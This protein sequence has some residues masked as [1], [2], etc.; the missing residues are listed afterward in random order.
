MD[1]DDTLRES[2]EHRRVQDAHE[3]GKNHKIDTG[4]AANTHSQQKIL[5]RCQ[6]SAHPAHPKLPHGLPPPARLSGCARGSPGSCFPFLTL[7]FQLA[8]VSFIHSAFYPL[9]GTRITQSHNFHLL[10]LHTWSIKPD[11]E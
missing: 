7:G 3:T 6:G 5:A 10:V 1:I 2:P 8:A 11:V 9:N 4:R